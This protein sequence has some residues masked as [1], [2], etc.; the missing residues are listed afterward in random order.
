MFNNAN[1][2]GYSLA[3]VAAVSGRDNNNGLF[4]DGSGALWIIVLFAILF[5]G[6]GG[7]GGNNWGGAGGGTPQ[8]ISAIDTDYISQGLRDIQTN[9]ASN[10][11]TLNN[12]NLSGFCDVKGAI[13]NGTASITNAVTNGFNTQN[14]ANLQNTNAIQRDIYTGTVGAMQNTQQL[15]ATLNGMASDQRADTA[16]L[17][18]N[19]ATQFCATNTNNSNNTRDIIDSQNAGTRAILDALQTNKVEAMQDRIAALTAENTALQFQAS[20]QAQ[21][22]YLIN[23]LRPS[24]VPSFPVAPPFYYGGNLGSI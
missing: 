7:Y 15:Q 2:G 1:N 17:N 16:A 12:E 23:Q 14:L 8:T 9:L 13:A 11:L 20:Q 24:P 3:D 19:L 4:G 22:T 5:G 6:W 10:F 21:N 18:Y